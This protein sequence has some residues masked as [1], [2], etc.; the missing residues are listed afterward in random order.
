[1]V[2]N[3]LRNSVSKIASLMLLTFTCF[4][5]NVANAQCGGN[6]VVGG[7]TFVPLNG[8]VPFPGNN[9]CY[10]ISTTGGDLGN[11]LFRGSQIAGAIAGTG[12][13]AA[14]L[15]T[16]AENAFVANAVLAYNAGVKA[17]GEAWG[18]PSNA[19]I[20]FTDIAAETQFVWS[21]GE[22]ICYTNWNTGEPNDFAIGEDFTEMLIMAPYILNGNPNDPFG[23]WNDWYNDNVPAPLPGAGPTRLRIVLE[24]GPLVTTCNP[25][26]GDQGCTLGYWKNHEEDWQGYTTAQTLESV[27]NVPDALNIDNVSL[28][29]ALSFQ[30]GP[31]VEGGARILMKQAVA[32]LLN[33]AHSDVDYPLTVAQVINQTNAALASDNR[34]TM[35]A[36]AGT[37]E[38]YNSLHNTALCADVTTTSRVQGGGTPVEKEFAISGYPNPSRGNFNVLINGLATEKVS[39]RVTDMSGRLIEQRANLAANQVVNI[40]NTYT[41]GLYYVEVVQGGVKK[42]LKMVKQ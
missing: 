29:D 21:S 41:P 34:N 9:H 4:N 32:A 16:A 26:T 19:W 22:P 1:M 28:L 7:V 6:I 2:L 25:P 14:T 39:I 5:F 36:L 10:Y 38:G 11:G 17:P 12:G 30:G 31:G 35:I 27:F 3:C 33:A 15:H 37:L 24:V 8:G 20:G 40:G 42:Q 13:Y 18:H 23:K